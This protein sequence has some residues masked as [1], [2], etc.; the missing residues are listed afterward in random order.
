[1]KTR[2]EFL[3]D[4]FDRLRKAGF[5]VEPLP[6]GDLAAEVYM[7][8]PLLCVIT[9]DGEIIYETYNTDNARTLEQAG[10][11][12]RR[13]LDCHVQPPFADMERMEPINLTSGSYYKVFESAAVVLL[14]R[15][16]MLF[17][18]EF[19]TCQKTAPKHN[20]RRFYREQ[21]FYDTAAAQ[22]SFME[23]S[24]LSL[25]SFPQF[26]TGELRLLVSCCARC[27]MLDNELDTTVENQINMLMA[28]IESYLPTEQ[29]LSPRHCFQHEIE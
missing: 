7:G 29:E 25:Q 4:F 10:E 6:D 2:A 20:S 11:E 18:Y 1:M 3:E 26:S 12:T 27:V 24:G 28:K 17:G 15:R 23:R 19:V 21:Y 16:T 22:G 8:N 5:R 13:A 9:Q 14:C